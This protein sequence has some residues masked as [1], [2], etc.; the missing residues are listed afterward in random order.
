MPPCAP[1]DLLFADGGWPRPR[2][3]CPTCANSLLIGI[4]LT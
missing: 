4:Q 1:V 2:S 3:S